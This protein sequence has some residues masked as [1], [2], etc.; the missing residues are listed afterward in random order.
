MPRT[1]KPIPTPGKRT[2]E[3]RIRPGPMRWCFPG[4]TSCIRT[5]FRARRPSGLWRRNGLVGGGASA[6]SFRW[7]RGGGSGFVSP[8][9]ARP[10]L[11]REKDWQQLA[12]VSELVRREFPDVTIVPVPT[13]REGDGLAMSSRNVRLNEVERKV[14]PMLSA[15]LGALAEATDTATEA[16]RQWSRLGGGWL[17]GGILGGCGRRDV[18]SGPGIRTGMPRHRSRPPRGS[19]A[20]RQR[21]RSQLIPRGGDDGLF[22]P[23]FAP[24]SIAW[25]PLDPLKSS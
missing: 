6:R 8:G 18:G 4:R 7:G 10:G 1:S 13:R 11:F 20:H 14:A 15:A 16:Q 25:E 12:V 9:G 5:A 2:F 22:S 23:N 21:S 19:Q 3:W 17:V 24:K